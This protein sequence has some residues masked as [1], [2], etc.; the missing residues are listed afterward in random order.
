MQG[1]SS[2]EVVFFRLLVVGHL[3]ASVDQTLLCRG[4]SFLL[5]DLLLD[6]C[7]GVVGLDVELDLAAGESADSVGEEGAVSG[8]LFEEMAGRW[9]RT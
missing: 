3:L 5:F 1:A 2:L 7:N 6:L 9:I 4:D 8:W